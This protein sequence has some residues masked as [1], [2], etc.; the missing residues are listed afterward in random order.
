MDQESRVPH[1][2]YFTMPREHF[3]GRL[4]AQPE[5]LEECRRRRSRYS[6]DGSIGFVS[7]TAVATDNCRLAMKPLT[8]G[9]GF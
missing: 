4:P 3:S 9:D 5:E 2:L 7:F 6:V 8:V 1:T